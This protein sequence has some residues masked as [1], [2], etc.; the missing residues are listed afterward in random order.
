[1]NDKPL[2]SAVANRT[3][4][5]TNFH[6]FFFPGRWWFGIA[7]L[8]LVLQR[9]LILILPFY[10]PSLES[11]DLPVPPL[12]YDIV[13]P[14]PA[15]NPSHWDCCSATLHGS[16]QEKNSLRS[17]PQSRSRMMEFAKTV[18]WLPW[19]PILD[20]C[21]LDTE[22]PARG[23]LGPPSPVFLCSQVHQADLDGKCASAA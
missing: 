20:C 18:D 14:E 15:Q 17:G 8:S 12:L 16:R 10:F 11:L 5:S 7:V 21:A 23:V 9:I 4:K 19:H 3:S 6:K 13:G 2:N 1:M 22:H